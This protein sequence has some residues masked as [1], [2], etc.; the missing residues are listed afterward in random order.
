MSRLLPINDKLVEYLYRDSKQ[1]NFVTLDLML[2][3]KYNA[4][5]H[6]DESYDYPVDYIIFK[7]EKYKTLFLLHYGNLL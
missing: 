4:S 1:E 3:V 6:T 2:L 7:D 5:I